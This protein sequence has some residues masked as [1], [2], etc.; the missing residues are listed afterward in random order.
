[1]ALIELRDVNV[2]FKQKK[3]VIHAVRNVSL[4]IERGDIYGIIG[5]SGAGKSTLARVINRLQ[6]PTSGK[7]S[8]NH[9]EI[10][11]LSGK[12]LRDERKNIGIVFQQFN[13][14]QTKTIAQNVAYPLIF[15]PNDQK[16]KEVDRL[17]K[18]VGLEDKRSVYPKQLSG[19]QMQRVAIA[20]AL[21]NHPQILISDE[22]TSALD[23]KTTQSILKLL[24]KLNQTLNLTIVL[25]T[26]EMDAIKS[27]CNKVA[28]M[29]DGK[30][31]END[32]LLN[33]FTHPKTNLS[34]SFVDESIHLK[35]S[36][37]KVADWPALKDK[38]ILELR[39][40]GDKTSKP[41]IIDLYQKYQIASSILFG[42]I[43]F[44]QNVPVGHLVIELPAD[45]ASL[46]KIKDYL[47]HRGISFNQIDLDQEAV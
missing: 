22:A 12:K 3:H 34:R 23:P 37:Q 2:D 9:Q 6:K 8:V 35:S 24:K 36:F 33:V 5:Y 31:V 26:H 28:V 17:L 30:V 14:M 18:L 13:L 1:M 40:V 27:I 20:R 21:A 29:D 16:R 41:I 47:S 25:I 15:K 38:N 43:E 10:T 44:I 46:S 32:S 19:G 42:N 11:H 39:Y 45:Q 7:V 4:K